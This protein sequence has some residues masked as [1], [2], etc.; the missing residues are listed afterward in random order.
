MVAGLEVAIILAGGVSQ[1]G[2]L[3]VFST[4]KGSAQCMET[5][6]CLKWCWPLAGRLRP[7][8]GAFEESGKPYKGLTLHGRRKH[9][10]TRRQGA[11]L[12]SHTPKHCERRSSLCKREDCQG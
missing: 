5:L 10:Q 7:S 6:L 2:Y 1:P 12:S 11:A 3:A 8:W 4:L 9:D